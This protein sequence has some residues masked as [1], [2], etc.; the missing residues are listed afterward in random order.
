MAFLKKIFGKS[1]PKAPRG[2]R[3]VAIES[4]ERLNPDAVKVTFAAQLGE[5][6]NFKPG[7]YINVDVKIDGKEERRSYSICSGLGE[8]LAI[9]IKQVEN[10]KVSTWFNQHA[11]VGNEILISMPDGNFTRKEGAKNC[12]A[13]AA[14]SGITPIV[15]LAKQIEADGNLRLFYGNRTEKDILFKSV[16]DGLKNTS[17]HYFLSREEKEGFGQGRLD[18]TTIVEEFKRDLSLLKADAYF[19]CGPEQM[20]LDAVEALKLFGVAEEKIHF[21]LFTTPV[22]MAPKVEVSVSN[23]KGSSEITVT[24]DGEDETFTIDSSKTVLDGALSDGMDAPYSCRGGVCS[25]CKAKILDGSVRMNIN[26]S[27]TDQEIADGYILTCQSHP[28][29]E[30][31]HISY[32]DV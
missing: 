10:G 20:I 22:L 21:E 15:S 6:S 31:L 24:I 30:K 3:S 16:L 25:T 2:Y 19:I 14:G 18:K 28:T 32:D 12:V 7:Q 5:A 4:I 27:L 29:S 11:E 8:P 1:E 26:Y 23:F 9:G 13:I 17:T